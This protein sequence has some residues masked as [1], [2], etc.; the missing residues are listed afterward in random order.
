MFVAVTVPAGAGLTLSAKKS[1]TLAGPS[2]TITAIVAV[3]NRP[4]TGVSVTVRFDP[5]PPNEIAESGTRAGFEDV[6]L[7]CKLPG[8]TSSSWTVKGMGPV[9]CSWR[10]VWLGMCERKGAVFG[11]SQSG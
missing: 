4:G 2:V 1:V 9:V 10:I 3:P 5:L 8:R 11:I 6:A 7:S